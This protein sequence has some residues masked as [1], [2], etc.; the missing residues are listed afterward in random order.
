MTDR[1]SAHYISGTHWD[2][3]WYRPFQEYRFLL[4]QILDQLLD[5]METSTDFRYFH[6][7]GQTCVLADYLEVRPENR[8]RLQRLISE[9][10]ILIGPW[11]TMPDL[12]CPGDDEALVRNL[13]LGQ[14][15]SHEWG[16][17]PMGV[18]YTCDMFG[19]PSQMPQIYRGF[20][21]PYCVLGR[22]TNEHT[23][24]A[25]FTWEA[26]DGS[27]VFTFKLQDYMGYGAFVGS[28]R[29][30]ENATDPND[31][32]VE[33][34][35]KESMRRYVGHEISRSNA[36]VLCLMD[37]LDHMP[38]ATDAARYLRL[39]HQAMPEIDAIHSA[40]P[41]FFRE[42]EQKATDLP[43]K[44]G[45]R[46]EPS[47]GPAPYLWLIPNCVS[48]RVQ[49]KQANDECLMLLERWA[50]PWVGLANLQ[51]AG[52]PERFLRIAWE[53]VLLNHAHDSICGCSVDQ[54]HRDMMYRFDQARVL[55]LQLR[56]QAYGFLTAGCADIARKEHEFTLTIANPLPV[57]RREVVVFD[58]DLPLDYPTS[59]KEGFRSQDV[60]SFQLQDADGNEVPYQRLSLDPRTSSRSRYAL[61]AFVGDP[62]HTRYTV[63]A[64]VDLPA[65][66]FTSLLVKPSE[67]PVRRMGSLRTGPN[68]A[69]NEHLALYVESNGTVTL[70]HKASGEIYT[71]LL[72]FEDRSEIGDGWFHGDTVNDEI[73]LSTGSQA[74]ISVMNDGPE[75]VTFRIETAMSLPERYDWHREK[76]S[77]GRA[78]LRL[79]SFI[80]LR[81]G[82]R[83]VEV[84]TVVDNNVEDHRLRLLLPTDVPQ[85][86]TWLA[87]QPYDVLE[88]DIALE[89]ETADWQEPE[90]AE[91]PFQGLQAV[92]AGNRGLA[93]LSA[94]GLHE[95][96]VQDDARRTMQVT[97]LRSYG[98][99]VG[100][101][102][103]RDGLE[104][105]TRA[106][107]Y[108]LMPFAGE[109]PR[110][111]ALRELAALQ[112]GLMVR[113]TG[114][115]PSGFPPMTGS[116]RPQISYLEQERGTL[117]L[118]ALKPA[119]DGSGLV[120]RLWNP[121]E[122]AQ[123]ERIRLWRKVSRARL[124]NLAEGPGDAGRVTKR[125]TAVTVEAGPK[126]VVTVGL[127][128]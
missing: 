58:V 107:R 108:A 119:E 99:T 48:S 30:L 61:P 125:G 23:T 8:D 67:R 43:L 13:L 5:L 17:E 57:A 12:F 50:E 54:V 93:F 89:P 3:E 46:R 20:G 4:V 51:G 41:D 77:D 26:P 31:P 24:P 111:E 32:Q 71:D 76:R 52:I 103:E 94:G 10:R 95:G 59:F 72:T 110:I 11:F 80:S 91:K 69:E 102:G 79:T 36:P 78:E 83:T 82:A 96:G 87:H 37:A 16:V 33:A 121:T 18:A 112:A 105:G 42:A 56:H 6:L 40:L 115:L 88:R 74:Q 9:G 15:I 21:L 118:S 55:A 123:T 60:K 63:A 109:L 122:E 98:R 86:K 75:M 2:R 73:A 29:V 90:I 126:Q 27:R 106:Y 25:F 35:A 44:R 1:Y 14:R 47:K 68:S 101:T 85:A 70:T 117:V 19:H 62:E 65:L 104:L 128:F 81:R 53:N 120:V 66:G 28:R 116:E 64:E 7:D 39:L 124:L 49:M 114:L 22:G 97:L 84:E 34:E 38:P 100:T 113:Q 127:E 92:G 45:E